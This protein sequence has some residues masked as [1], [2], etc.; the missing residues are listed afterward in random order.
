MNKKLKNALIC[1][2]AFVGAAGVTGGVIALSKNVIFKN[3]NSLSIEKFTEDDSSGNSGEVVHAK[4]YG[5]AN[6]INAESALV[7]TDDARNLS[8]NVNT[9]E[10]TI[11]SDFD[12]AE[13]YK[14]IK[15]WTDD[16]NNVFVQVPKHYVKYTWDQVEGTLTTKISLEQYEGFQLYP[17]FVKDDGTEI[18]YL[19]IGKYSATGSSSRATSV[20]GLAT[21]VNV[22]M[23]Q[24][25]TAA[26]ANGEGYQQLDYWTYAMLQD[27]FKI[28][29]ATTNSQAI[30][31][32]CVA[33]SAAQVSGQCDFLG[34]NKSGWNTE[35]GVMAYR[36]IENIYG[37]VWQWC[38]GVSFSNYEAYVCTK[39]SSYESGKTT[40]DYERVSYTLASGEGNPDAIGHDDNH[41]FVHLATHYNG[42]DYDNGGY[43]ND[44]S[45][46]GY[47]CLFVGG[48]Y[49]YGSLA[50]FWAFASGTAS[51]SDASIGGRVLLK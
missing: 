43:Y 23:D 18:D 15:E 11:S 10:G 26:K 1:V 48:Y 45:R 22:T 3:N 2:L 24:M 30:M 14:D 12:N 46:F 20:S 39:V 31:R 8:Y 41:P 51:N 44:R 17:C 33:Q 32:G 38:D 40:G 27:L 28:E 50:G 21:L 7:R 37:N 49:A 25:R 16:Q 29:F 42:T 34:A 9:A 36:G 4:I 35:T 19:N 5:V 6:E 13:I 47:P